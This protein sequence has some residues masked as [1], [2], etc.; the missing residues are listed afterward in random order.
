MGQG[1]NNDKLKTLE[2]NENE[3]TTYSNLWEAM[4]VVLGGEFR[5]L[6]ATPESSGKRRKHTQEGREQEISK[7]RAVCFYFNKIQ[8]YKQSI[9]Q[10][11]GS[12]G[13]STI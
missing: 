13:K 11:V 2:F 12:L 3:Y 8:Q 5:A 10:R 4:E 1:R 6:S 9:K 7:P